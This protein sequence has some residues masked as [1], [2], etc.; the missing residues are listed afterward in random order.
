MSGLRLRRLGDACTSS[1]MPG[2]GFTTREGALAVILAVGHPSPLGPIGPVRVAEPV[3][4]PILSSAATQ[5]NQARNAAP[6]P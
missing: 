3:H 1:T 6:D 4:G 5:I 2:C